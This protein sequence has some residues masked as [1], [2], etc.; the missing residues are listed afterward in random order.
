VHDGQALPRRRSVES[1]AVPLSNPD[2]DL[3]MFLRV[4]QPVRSDVQ[5]SKGVETQ[6]SGDCIFPDVVLVLDSFSHRHHPSESYLKLWAPSIT[7]P[8]VQIRMVTSLNGPT[9]TGDFGGR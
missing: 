3:E 7:P 4:V 6:C 9:V 8:G 1:W 2:G 5:L